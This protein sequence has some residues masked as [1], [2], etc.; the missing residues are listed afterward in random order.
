MLVRFGIIPLL[1]HYN[2]V[3]GILLAIEYHSS[4]REDLCFSFRICKIQALH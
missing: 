1:T 4:K 2:K 3:Y